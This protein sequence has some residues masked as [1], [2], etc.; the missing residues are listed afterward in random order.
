[1]YKL[2][3]FDLDGTLIDSDAMLKVSLLEM[4]AKY[5]PDFDVPEGHTVQF[6]GPP[7]AQTLAKEFPK[8]DTE[9]LAK[10]FL[11][12]SKKNY[13][14]YTSLFPGVEEILSTL[15]S[16]G[17]YVGVV[18]NKSRTATNYTFKLL[19]LTDLVQ[20]SVCGN[21]V[22]VGKPDPS[23]IFKL[24]KEFGISDKKEVIYIGDSEYDY[25]TAK[26]AG[27]DFGYVTWSPRK[28][29]KA[30]RIAIKIGSFFDFAEKIKYE[31]D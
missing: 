8:E 28:L 17:K 11:E 6:S 3:I 19:G 26:N 21:E 31:K 14:L 15:L 10:E 1:M 22:E 5:R 13:V 25:L 18:T 24:M 12:I 20:K 30:A 7:I 2:Y 4:Y 23:G 29:D 16:L 27:I 9:K